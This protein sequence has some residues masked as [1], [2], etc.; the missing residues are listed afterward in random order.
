MARTLSERVARGDF[1]NNQ[2][3]LSKEILALERDVRKWQER[4]TLYGRDREWDADAKSAFFN[5]ERGR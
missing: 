5:W 3:A 2:H 4:A 1:K